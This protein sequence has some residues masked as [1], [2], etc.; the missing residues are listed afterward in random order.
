MLVEVAH[1]VFFGEAPAFPRGWD[2]GGVEAMFLEESP[3]GGWE[4][5]DGRGCRG[6]GGLGL[7][8]PW[9]LRRSD[10]FARGFLAGLRGSR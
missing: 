3:Y 2:V 7:C 1:D 10:L 6:G 8:F 9:L 5:L 4:F